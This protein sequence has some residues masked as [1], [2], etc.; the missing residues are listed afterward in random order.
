MFN[1]SEFS[2]LIKVAMLCFIIRIMTVIKVKNPEV[3]LGK[4]NDLIITY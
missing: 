1:A 3:A 4:V 2:V